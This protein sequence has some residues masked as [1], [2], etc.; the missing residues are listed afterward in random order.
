M[1]NRSRCGWAAR[2]PSGIEASSGAWRSEIVLFRIWF[3][4]R[5]TTDEIVCS[6]VIDTEETAGRVVRK[7]SKRQL[8]EHFPTRGSV[9]EI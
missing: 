6:T 1:V 7:V 3:A 2:A 8:L 9:S 4:S 5:W